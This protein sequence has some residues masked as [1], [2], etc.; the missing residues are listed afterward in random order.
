VPAHVVEALQLSLRVSNDQ[1]RFAE[2]IGSDVITRLFELANV[3]NDLPRAM[4]D[5]P[6][7]LISNCGILVET[8]R[9]SAGVRDV[10]ID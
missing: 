7:F 10:G 9:Q 5:L 4:K 1:Q 3:P 8:G 2:K 6:R